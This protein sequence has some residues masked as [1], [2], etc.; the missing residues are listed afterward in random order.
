MEYRDYYK[1]LGVE[2]N[3]STDEI[4][5]AYRK[6]AMQHHPDH[7]PGNK[8]AEDRFKE[9]NEANEV[10]SDPKKR[11]HYDQ[12]GE[13]YS[14]WQQSGGRGSDFRWED[15]FSQSPS[16]VRM[17]YSGDIGELFGGGFSDFFNQIFGGMHGARASQSRRQGTAAS[18]QPQ[19]HQQN[20]TISLQE[21]YTGTQRMLQIDGKRMEVII[22]PGAHTGTK[23]RMAGVTPTAPGG[24]KG[25]LYL[26]IDVA[27]DGRFERKGDDL[28]TESSI[29]L[30]TAILGGQVSV[31]TPAGNVMLSIP[32]GTQPGQ[33]FRLAGRGMPKLRSKQVHGDLYTKVKVQIP[34]KLTAEQKALYEKL[35]QS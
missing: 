18:L 35:R 24:Q 10:L 12:L 25:D 23:V 22:P 30:Y 14:R 29:D 15:W 1:I 34:R 3:A 7:N 33:T 2:R 6:L 17:E 21:A 26:V 32:A 13:S 16:G 4:K 9:I 27:P 28:Y 19:R 5:R 8:Q 20:V 31:L 11:A